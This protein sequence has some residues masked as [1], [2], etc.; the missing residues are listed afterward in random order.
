[1]I[2]NIDLVS[3][4][5]LSFWNSCHIHCLSY[6]LDVSRGLAILATCRAAVAAAAKR[7]ED[8][9]ANKA[10]EGH[11][12][13]GSRAIEFRVGIVSFPCGIGSCKPTY[14]LILKKGM[15]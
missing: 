14:L 9:E 4:G 6:C 10:D 5:R 12:K 2:F 3:V 15:R 13:R 11:E 7:H 1:M 8:P